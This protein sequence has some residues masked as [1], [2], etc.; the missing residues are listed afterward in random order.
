MAAMDRDALLAELR[1]ILQVPT[2]EISDAE[3]VLLL[4]SGV[5][6]VS[7]ADFWP[8]LEA[9]ATMSTV[10]ATRTIALPSDFE[11]ALALVDDDNDDRVPYIAPAALFQEVGNDT[12]NSGTFFKY[13]TI[14]EGAVYLTPIP[15]GAD[16]DRFTLYYYKSG[17]QL[18]A[19]TTT[20]DWHEAFHHILVEY[21][22]WKVYERAEYY[23]PSA[24]AFATY[25]KYLA[26]MKL[27]YAR[28][29]KRS[30]WIAGDGRR[31]SSRDLNIPLLNN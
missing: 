6:E 26:D 5:D 20:P 18:S 12:G 25:N 28:R 22:K 11:Y 3:I 29:A 21:V 31:T 30:P 17:T 9:S 13:W 14:W 24:V 4:N 23:E 27:W 10:D 8:F 19:G 7:I 15:D 1:L 2:G 16:T